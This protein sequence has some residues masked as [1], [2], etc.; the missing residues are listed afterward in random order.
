[1][2]APEESEIITIRY[3]EPV[4]Y[5]DGSAGSVLREARRRAGLTQAQLASRAG[6]TQSVISAY[7]SGRRQ[8]SLPVL[9]SLVHAAG[10]ELSIE[11]R[12][13][14][15][16]LADLS[17]PLGDRIRRNRRQLVATA[18]DFGVRNL[19]VFGSAAR[20]EDGADSDLDLLADLPADLG[21]FGLGRLRAALEEIVGARVDIVPAADL[22]P[23]VRPRVEREAVA[24]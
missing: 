23:E 2:A 16:R 9:Q 22:K 18:A 11:L 4:A 17:G 1:M 14:P 13:P 21:L 6:I 12:L 5:N 24:L 15:A 10:L 7:E 3:I 20:G 8:P 19:R